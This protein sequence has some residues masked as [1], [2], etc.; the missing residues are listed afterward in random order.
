MKRVASPH[1]QWR[2]STHSNSM[3]GDCV[4]VAGVGDMIALRDSKAP[5]GPILPLHPT[6]WHNLLARLKDG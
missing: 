4:E 5:N 2:K 6:A 3:S 1:P